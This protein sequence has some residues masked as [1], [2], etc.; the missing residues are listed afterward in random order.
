MPN[1]FEK[2][3]DL[4][5]ILAFWDPNQHF[6]E[7]LTENLDQIL[8]AIDCKGD[9]KAGWPPRA[10]SSTRGVWRYTVRYSILFNLSR[11]GNATPVTNPIQTLERDQWKGKPLWRERSHWWS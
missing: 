1:R 3:L 11:A 5:D 2:Y 7:R 9:A 10:I 8:H 4:G 6:G